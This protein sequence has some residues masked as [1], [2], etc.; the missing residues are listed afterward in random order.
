MYSKTDEQLFKYLL[1]LQKQG[2]LEV[3]VALECL[4]H[5]N[6]LRK[7]LC[8]LIDSKKWTINE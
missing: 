4:D 1:S 6:D 7:E 5:V 8:N 2:D 3:F